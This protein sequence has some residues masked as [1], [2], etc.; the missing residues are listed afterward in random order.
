MSH[1]TLLLT[2]HKKPTQTHT[3]TYV[4]DLRTISPL[5]TDGWQVKWLLKNGD[6]ISLQATATLR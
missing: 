1:V 2:T 4:N 6:V 5:M 3:D